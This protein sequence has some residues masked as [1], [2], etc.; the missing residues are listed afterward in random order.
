MR[1]LVWVGVGVVVTVVVLR[2]GKRLVDAYVPAGATEVVDGVTRLRRAWDTARHE[3][4]AGLA[5][6]EEQLRND[7]VG[8]VDVE[9]LRAER[10]E[11]VDALRRAWSSRGDVPRGW[12]AGPTD[13]PDDD[14]GYAF[15]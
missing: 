6:R 7:L 8:D 12:A 10:P 11:R 14:D 4:A 13:D 3:F 15:F 5:E 2:Q 1:R 9:R